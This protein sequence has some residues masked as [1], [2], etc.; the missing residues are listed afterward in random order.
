MK[1][2][3]IN[4]LMSDEGESLTIYKCTAN[5]PTIGI[6]RNLEKGITKE[7]SSYLFMNDLK[8]ATGD[9]SKNFKWFYVINEI[10][11]GVLI[12]MCFN[13]GLTRFMKFKKM[14]AA[15]EARD[16]EEAARQMLDSKWANQV[17]DRATRLA[18]QMLEG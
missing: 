17:G 12:N 14:I 10:R 4:Q 9:L 15:L 1:Q 2:E 18:K 11:Q 13:L 5:I 16:Y 3:A 7:E 6:G 8:D